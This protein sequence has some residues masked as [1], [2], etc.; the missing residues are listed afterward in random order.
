MHVTELVVAAAIAAG[1]HGPAAAEPASPLETDAQVKQQLIAMENQSW[2]AWK[3]HDG[4]FFNSFLSD[5]HV[6]LSPFGATSKESVVKGVASGG[7]TVKDYSIGQFGFVR[8]SDDA[9]VLTYHA[10]QTTTCGSVTVP[11]PVWATSVYAKRNGRWMNVVYEHT[12]AKN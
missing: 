12:P 3:G 8:L 11:S 9:A 7:C 4:K 6:E 1:L 5:D 2:V 10:A